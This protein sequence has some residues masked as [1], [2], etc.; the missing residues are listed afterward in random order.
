MGSGQGPGVRCDRVRSGAEGGALD[1][2]AGRWWSVSVMTRDRL[3]HLFR[4]LHAW[5]RGGQRA[6]HKPLLLLLALGRVINNEERLVS[7]VDIERR[8][9]ELLRRFGPPRN[10]FHPQFPFGLEAIGANYR[11]L[12][13]SEV[14]GQSDPIRWFLDYHDKPLR[15]P[16]NRRFG[17]DPEYV[18]WHRREVFRRPPLG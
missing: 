7:Y 2:R 13:S 17:P 16:R 5:K 9:K 14:H 15:P 11:V 1:E 18:N 10:A 8:L 4:N 6:P 12:I 3:L